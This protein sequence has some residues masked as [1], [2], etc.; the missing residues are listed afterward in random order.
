MGLLG[1]MARTE[2]SEPGRGL[3]QSELCHGHDG[4]RAV[5]MGWVCLHEQKHAT[6]LTWWGVLFYGFRKP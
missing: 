4:V 3:T 5:F 6:G 2:S 1:K